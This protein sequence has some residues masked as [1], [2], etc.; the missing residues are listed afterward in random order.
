M[1]IFS[2]GGAALLVSAIAYARVM[3]PQH[4]IPE[5]TTFALLGAGLVGLVVYRLIKKHKE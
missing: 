5:P 1:L 4:P 3:P 2:V